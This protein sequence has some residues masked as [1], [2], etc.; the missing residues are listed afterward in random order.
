MTFNDN[1]LGNDLEAVIADERY[2]YITSFSKKLIIAQK[3][4]ENT[5]FLNSTIKT[6]SDKV[7]KVLTHKFFGIPI[8]IAILF[9]I[10]H[11][12][13]SEDL[14]FLN[15]LG[16]VDITSFAGTPYEGLFANGGIS[17]IGVIFTNL[18][19]NTFDL[20]TS[21]IANGMNS[22]NVNP[23][24]TGLVCDGIITGVFSVFGF[25]PYDN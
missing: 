8:F 15:A 9:V 20:I 14:F 25:L 7:D 11:L 18:F 13:F 2:K 23:V 16:L 21:S 24:V 10:F 6:K 22:A 4:E 5:E 1:V 3:K 17:S 19:N 12:T